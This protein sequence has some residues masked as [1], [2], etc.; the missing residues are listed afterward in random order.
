ML[1][2]EL[3]MMR[4]EVPNL[5]LRGSYA[6]PTASESLAQA[7]QYAAMTELR[8]E[9]QSVRAQ[10]Q[11]LK[12]V[13][14]ETLAN[15]SEQHLEAD[16]SL[17]DALTSALAQSREQGRR[18]AKLLREAMLEATQAQHAQVASILEEQLGTLE[19]I[20]TRSSSARDGA[21]EPTAGSVAAKGIWGLLSNSLTEDEVPLAPATAT[22][23]ASV[24]ST[25]VTETGLWSILGTPAPVELALN[26][27]QPTEKSFWDMFAGSGA[28]S[29]AT[30]APTERVTVTVSTEQFLGLRDLGSSNS[31]DE[32]EANE[33]I[34]ATTTPIA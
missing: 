13:V 8:T 34:T 21:K 11:G 20:R 32:V 31:T 5:G 15:S 33:A 25:V 27:T 4:S 14:F 26:S 29:E 18:D 23:T 17:R 6:K 19:A 24:S 10:V 12:R 28:D 22:T 2:Q 1:Q 16:V 7:E 3:Q 30:T 9:L